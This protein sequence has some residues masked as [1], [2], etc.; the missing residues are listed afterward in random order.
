[1]ILIIAAHRD[2]GGS[3]GW[4][5]T[6]IWAEGFDDSGRRLFALSR[7]KFDGGNLGWSYGGFLRT[8]AC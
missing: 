3:G 7:L 8:L 4:M 6:D 1:V 2:T 5:C